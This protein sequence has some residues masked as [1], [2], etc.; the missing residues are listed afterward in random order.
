MSNWKHWAMMVYS[1]IAAAWGVGC[2]AMSFYFSNS[3]ALVGGM[4]FIIFGCLV[5]RDSFTELRG[6]A[7]WHG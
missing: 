2:I 3:L 7:Q 4:A 5:F 6:R 1:V